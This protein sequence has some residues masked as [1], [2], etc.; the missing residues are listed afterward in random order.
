MVPNGI[1]VDWYQLWREYEEGKTK[2]A[3]IVKH[4]DKF[5]MIAQA[6]EYEKKYNIGTSFTAHFWL[7][8]KP[9]IGF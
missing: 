1:G 9:S 7:I 4:L 6:F 3:I 2:E 8:S 5:D